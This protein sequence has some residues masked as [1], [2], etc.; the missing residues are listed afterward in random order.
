MLDFSLSLSK[1]SESEAFL[2]A[3][4]E[5]LR[6]LLTLAALGGSCESEAVLARLCRISKPRATAALVFWEEANIITK[7]EQKCDTA[8]TITEEFE[9][10]I[11]VSALDEITAKEC[12]RTIRDS[13]LA[14]LLFECATIMGKPALSTEEAKVISS[15]YTQYAL[16]EE[17]I[18]TLAAHIFEKKGKLSARAIAIEAERL[19]KIGVGTAEALEKYIEETGRI[20]EDEWQFRRLIGAYQRTLSKPEKEYIKK[21]YG[22]FSFDGEIIGLAYDITIDKTSK[23]SLPYMDKLLSHWHEAGCKTLAACKA[24]SEKERAELAAQK[25]KKPPKMPRNSAPKPRYGDFDVNEA[26]AKAL[27]RSYAD[28]ED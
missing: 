1:L 2:E 17:Y 27:E 23:I 10:R 20:T 13:N 3:S 28:D 15:V 14:D 16:D 24:I 25:S 12:A 22:D 26:F 6:T 21:W 18:I 8:P 9:E 19:A 11:R 7:K 4:K 5:E